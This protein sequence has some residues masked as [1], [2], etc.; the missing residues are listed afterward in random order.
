MS[1]HENLQVATKVAFLDCLHGVALC[2]V[3]VTEVAVWRIK[4]ESLRKGSPFM[5][6]PPG[7]SLF[8][9]DM[10]VRFLGFTVKKKLSGA[11]R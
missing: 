6:L 8:L 11:A 4:T 2:F 10:D 7:Q 5:L 9:M 3:H 1:T